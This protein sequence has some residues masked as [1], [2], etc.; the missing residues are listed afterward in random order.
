MQAHAAC[1]LIRTAASVCSLG[2]PSLCIWTV[3]GHGCINTYICEM[4]MICEPGQ[5]PKPFHC[6]VGLI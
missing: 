3:H 4:A 1:T 5:L 2:M 6:V